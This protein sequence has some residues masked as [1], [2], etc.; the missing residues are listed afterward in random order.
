MGCD[1]GQCLQVSVSAQNLMAATSLGGT[2]AMAWQDGKPD[3]PHY[4]QNIASQN[5]FHI[6]M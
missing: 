6:S 1:A 4:P 3:E 2:G 5:A